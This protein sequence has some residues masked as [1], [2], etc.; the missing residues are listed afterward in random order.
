MKHISEQEWSHAGTSFPKQLQNI[1]GQQISNRE[2]ENKSFAMCHLPNHDLDINQNNEGPPENCA[3][4]KVLRTRYQSKCFLLVIELV[5]SFFSVSV[6][7]LQGRTRGIAPICQARQ[8]CMYLLHTS[9]SISYPEIGQLFRRDRTTISHAC[10]VVEDL[11][12]DSD[13]DRNLTRLELILDTIRSMHG[14]A[15]IPILKEVQ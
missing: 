3:D 9:L 1:S 6:E 7:S 12:D 14:G 10:M 4:F 13:I 5:S 2:S 11:R 15:E 8:I